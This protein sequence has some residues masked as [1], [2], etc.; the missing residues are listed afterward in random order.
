MKK[1]GTMQGREVFLFRLFCIS[2]AG[3]EVQNS[4]AIR[5]FFPLKKDPFW[6]YRSNFQL[7]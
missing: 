3:G 7:K 1:L 6:L 5:V 2:F 4:I